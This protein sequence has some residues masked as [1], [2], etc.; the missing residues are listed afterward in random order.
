MRSVSKLTAL[1]CCFLALTS[2]AAI[3]ATY[4][5]VSGASVAF[6]TY[7]PLGPARRDTIGTI[8]VT[9]TGSIGDRV[10]YSLLLDPG[11]NGVY[12]VMTNDAYELYYIIYS[13]NGY[14]QIWGDGTA[15]TGVVSDSYTMATSRTSRTY[16]IYGRIPAGQKRAKSG[17][18]SAS[19]RITLTY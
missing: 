3:A 2:L 18:Y 5:D 8:S 9:C 11:Q 17:T 13:D 12:G 7:D 16:P 19:V 10:N 15:G 1:L 14:T 6:G 4:C